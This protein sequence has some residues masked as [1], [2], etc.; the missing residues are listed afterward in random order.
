MFTS[1]C[2]IEGFD[3]FVAAAVVIVFDVYVLWLLVSVA[4][5]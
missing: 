3:P 2:M 4:W 1:A 5:C